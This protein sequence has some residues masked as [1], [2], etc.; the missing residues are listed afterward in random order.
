MTVKSIIELAAPHT[1][2]A[3]TIPVFL[4]AMLGASLEH[5]FSPYLFFSVLLTSIFLQC[6]VNTLND[7]ADFIKGTDTIEN[8][9][10]PTDA[11]I[12][13]NN[14]NPKDARNIGIAFII[15]AA[16]S[17]L[18]AILMTGWVP[19]LFGAVGV[20]VLGS[21]SLS[22]LPLSH[23]PLGE[24]VSGFVMGGIITLASYYVFTMEVNPWI[25]V[26]AVPAMITI[27]LIMMGNNISD[28]EK[29]MNAGRKTLA[30]IL[31]R[32]RTAALLN[33]LVIITAAVVAAI[34]IFEFTR[35]AFLI[36]LMAASII[37]PLIRMNSG[38]FVFKSRT[39]TMSSILAVHTRL[40]L[41]YIAMIGADI[42][43]GVL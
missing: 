6:A 38:G 5:Q 7:Y 36:P 12:I 34:V 32:K 17:G 1:W 11:S 43:L 29:D 31:Q 23:L 22:K 28:I 42:I 2:P 4:A 3:S 8:S 24:I 19:V 9:E 16:A 30:C 20:A 35:G 39:V 25:L 14:L 10:D 21:Y 40:N 41:Y 13:Y 26:Y 33:S 18:Y 37:M 15:L 27:G